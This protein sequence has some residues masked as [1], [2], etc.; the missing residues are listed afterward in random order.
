[1][2][3]PLSVY[4]NGLAVITEP[5]DTVIVYRADSNKL[6]TRFMQMPSRHS[7]LVTVSTIATGMAAI[8][9]IIHSIIPV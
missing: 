9:Y 7:N 2:Q 4:I 1:M 3:N 6:Y 8:L 5:N